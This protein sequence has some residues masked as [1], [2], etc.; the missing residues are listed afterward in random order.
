[1]TNK[2][3]LAAKEHSRG[4]GQSRVSGE[5]E[6]TEASV[7]VVETALAVAGNPKPL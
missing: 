5:A 6:P 1:M 4:V 3:A 2:A 7:N